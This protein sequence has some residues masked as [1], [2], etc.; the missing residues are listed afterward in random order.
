[1]TT[2]GKNDYDSDMTQKSYLMIFSYPNSTDFDID[3]TE[4]IKNFNNIEINLKEK[5]FIN[6]NLFG[7]IFYGIKIISFNNEYIILS[8]N[9]RNE[10]NK[11]TI[12]KDEEKIELV[13]SQKI[14][15][16]KTG[17]IEYAMVLTEPDYNIFNNYSPIID[18]SYCDNGEGEKN[19]F[20]QKKNIYVGKTSYINVILN[21]NSDLLTNNCTNDE[22]CD[23]CTNDNNMICITCKYSYKIE[24]EKKICLSQNESIIDNTINNICS[25]EDAIKNKC[26]NNIISISQLNE[27][28]NKI[29]NKNYTINKENTINKTLN[30]IIQ[31]ST[32]ED[33][34]NTDDPDI[35]NI[36]FGECEILLKKSNDIPLSEKLI[37]YKTDIKSEDLSTIY[38]M[39]EIYNPFTL[40]KLDLSVC[41]DAQITINVPTILNNNIE[42]LYDSLSEFGYNI[43]DGNDSFY[44]DICATY[45]T[46]NG[47]DMLLSDRKEDIF[48]EGQNQTICQKGCKLQSYN[49][50]NK[51]AKCNCSIDEESSELTDLNIEDL[52]SKTL[53]EDNFYKTLTNSN[54]R[55][56]KCFKLLFNSKM[57]KNIG[58]I[59]MII[60]I[61]LFFILI[62]I[63][64]TT[65]KKIIRIHI[66][67]IVK[68]TINNNLMNNNNT[69]KKINKRNK[70]G[71]TM[72]SVSKASNK[73]KNTNYEPPKKIK[74]S[75]DNKNMKNKIGNN[76][77]NNIYQSNIYLNLS[78]N[79]SNKALKSK[80]NQTDI[81][82]KKKK[83]KRKLIDIY[84]K[85]SLFF[86]HDIKYK[87]LNDRELNSLE[88]ELAI[89]YDNRTYFQYYWSL[90]K[91]KQLIFFSF[92]PNKDY[93]LVTIKM[94]LFLISF[95][96]YFT[97]NGFFF[98]D[99]T[100]HKIYK[101]KGK[102]NIINQIPQILYST[103]VSS[104]IQIILKTLSLSEKNILGLK[105]IKDN[106]IVINKSK[107][108]EFCLKI[109]LLIFF[110][111]S[112]L[113][114]V[115]FWYFISCFCAVYINTQ[116]ILIEDTLI[117]FILSM[118]YPFGLNLLPGI[119]RISS[120][121]AK[122]KD[123]NCL[124]KTGNIIALI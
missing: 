81:S 104:V 43:F 26:K 79:K 47:T 53:I 1:M 15:I 78:M 56:L 24:D 105:E 75:K 25:S 7:Y 59:I 9:S 10:I 21:T 99:N 70:T 65:C 18:K 4:N 3:I 41:N 74:K 83:T 58:E 69:K 20:N 72:E 37:I 50:T 11:D 61:I 30:A 124:Y 84:K 16:P 95:S 68:N 12:L 48:T 112:S 110:I 89:Q 60:I 2:S 109:K 33:Q 91:R 52:F 121:R 97:I 93:N 73:Y 85:K 38:V 120:L 94:S 35:S 71:Y 5:C 6:N 87:N 103:M 49:N 22:Y 40:D 100:M 34:Q 114:M 39:Y 66:S 86:K 63:C 19:F 122:N 118:I 28:K 119:F 42:E 123:K 57:A 27:I 80:N 98:N 54:F 67:L 82:P 23:I 113:V 108:I 29:L 115:F 62:I 55:V 31:L 92:F 46:I 106:K 17:L 117:S 116:I 88:Y 90:V 36:D 8:V 45:T 101:G 111:L 51:K 44:Q 77:S 13:L 32:L 64:L 107:E 14:N 102:I 96:L 76:H